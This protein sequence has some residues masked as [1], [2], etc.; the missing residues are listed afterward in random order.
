MN[1]NEVAK[2][3]E[4][5]KI[6]D[7]ATQSKV[8]MSSGGEK[9]MTNDMRRLLV[10]KIFSARVVNREA[11]RTQVPRILQTRGEVDIEIVG[12]NIFVVMFTSEAERRHALL[13]GPWNFFN[14][15]MVFKAPI[16]L[17]SPRDIC[18]DVWSIWVQIHNMSFACMFPVV[19]RRIG[20]KRC[21]SLKEDKSGEERIVILRYEKLPDFC[22]ACGRVG[23][24]VRFY[25]DSNAD[26]SHLAFGSWLRATKTVETRRGRGQFAKGVVVL[27]E[28][29]R[30][31]D[32]RG[33]FGSDNGDADVGKGSM[34]EVAEDRM[35]GVSMVRAALT[36]ADKEV[37]SPLKS[38]GGAGKGR[39]WL[40]R[41]RGKKEGEMDVPVEFDSSRGKKRDIEGEVGDESGFGESGERKRVKLGSNLPNDMMAI[42]AEA[43][44][45][46]R[47]AQ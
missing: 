1:P 38:R 44:I 2:L 12:D 4:E 31:E 17:Q 34:I 5:L 7:E 16:G 32:D 15:L 24:V 6:T 9:T 27:E 25:E 28:K 23:H 21:V 22:H 45:H 8:K 41:A 33:S 35:D 36:E 37:T 30:E 26:K 29:E 11:L 47:R 46:P 43:D 14:S 18:F 20:E 42:T 10:G 3:V 13:N 19:V 39:S 40:R